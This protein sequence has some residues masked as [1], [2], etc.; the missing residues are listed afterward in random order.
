MTDTIPEELE[1]VW[2]P[3]VAEAFEALVPK[4]QEFLLEYLRNNHNGTQ[5]YYTT[6]GKNHTENVA[7]SS[8][9]RLLRSV[10]I[11]AVLSAFQ[12]TNTADLFMV[13][14]ALEDAIEN[15]YKPIFG[16][17]SD[18]QPELIQ[19]I[20]DY[21]ARIKAADSLMNLHGFKA[22]EKKEVSGS[23]TIMSTPLDSKL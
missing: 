22:A 5:A 20:P 12:K 16:K 11:E 15:A 2:D 10:K 18:G 3:K 9:W 7:S 4:H 17:D 21:A 13:K 14:R 8:A 6:Y 19:E 23:I 1:T